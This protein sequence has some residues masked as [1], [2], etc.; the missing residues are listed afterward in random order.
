MLIHGIVLAT[1]DGIE[2]DLSSLL[3]ALEEV[4]ILSATS[5]RLLIWVM[6]KDLLAVGALD[7]LFGSLVSVLR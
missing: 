4:I 6:A 5:S 7:L 1:L 2:K 3:D